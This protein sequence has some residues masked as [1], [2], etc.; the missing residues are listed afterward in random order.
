MGDQESSAPHNVILEMRVWGHTRALQPSEAY[1]AV[2]ALTW[3]CWHPK[4]ACAS[5]PARTVAL[6]T[7]AGR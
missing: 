6:K 3:L 5:E 2:S 7:N 1:L 4:C